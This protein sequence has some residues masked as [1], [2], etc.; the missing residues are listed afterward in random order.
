M[1]RAYAPDEDSQ[2]V[3]NHSV[4]EKLPMEGAYKAV[5]QVLM[6]LL[7]AAGIDGEFSS[8]LEE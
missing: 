5:Q 1:G 2:N 8:V 7:M 6:V 3:L 4:H